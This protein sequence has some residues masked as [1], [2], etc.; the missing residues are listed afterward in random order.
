M[1]FYEMY[2]VKLAC[3]VSFKSLESTYIR[4]V[5]RCLFAYYF[6]HLVHDLAGASS[7]VTPV[8]LNKKRRLVTKNPERF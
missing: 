6:P 1:V 2:V 3:F 5:A 8:V 7:E 4:K